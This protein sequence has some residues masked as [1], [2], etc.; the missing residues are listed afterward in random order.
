MNDL[1]FSMQIWEPKEFKFIEFRISKDVFTR[2]VEVLNISY[3]LKE[4]KFLWF[5]LHMFERLI[6]L[7]GESLGFGTFGIMSLKDGH[8]K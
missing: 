4:F 7:N 2:Y 8:Y 6:A 3:A 1:D 5:M